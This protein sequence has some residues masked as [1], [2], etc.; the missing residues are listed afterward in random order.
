MAQKK[1]KSQPPSWIA[2]MDDPNV[3]YFAAVKAFNLY[4]KHKEKPVE[5]NELFESVEDK[6]KEEKLERKRER[7]REDDPAKLYAFEYKRFLWWKEQVEPFVLPDGRIKSMD[8]RIAEWKV[9]K[10]HKH[11]KGEKQEKISPKPEK[12]N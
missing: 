9:Q 12:K 1:S 11:T 10:Q 5:E 6:E 3:N 8:E 4:W 7:L 2:L